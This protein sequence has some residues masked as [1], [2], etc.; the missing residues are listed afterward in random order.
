[1]RTFSQNASTLLCGSCFLTLDAG[2]GSGSGSDAGGGGGGG[3]SSF[4]KSM[5]S[6]KLLPIFGFARVR[7]IEEVVCDLVMVQVD[8]LK[9][10]SKAGK[11]A[12]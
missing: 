10:L 1:M 6:V 4:S 9:K 3:G 2:A 7:C 5:A 8:T 12:S 11:M